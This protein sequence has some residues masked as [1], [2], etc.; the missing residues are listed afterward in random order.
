MLRWTW[1][2]LET[3]CTAVA[4]Q[5]STLPERRSREIVRLRPASY[6]TLDSGRLA[7]PGGGDRLVFTAG[8]GLE[9]ELPDEDAPGD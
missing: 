5:S 7:L 1:R 2:E 3:Y 6:S 9:H 4:R 8:R